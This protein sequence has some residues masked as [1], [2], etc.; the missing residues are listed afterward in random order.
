M[1]SKVGIFIYNGVEA[2][3]VVGPLEVF[4]VA[5]ELNGFTL[6]ET[7]VFAES[8]EDV[9]TVNGLRIL[10]EHTITTLPKLDVLII[11]GGEGIRAVIKDPALMNLISAVANDTQYMLTVCTGAFAA[12]QLG[13]LNGRPFCTHHSCYH[14]VLAIAPEALPRREERFVGDGRLF[15][16]AGVTAG[17]ELALHIVQLMHGEETSRKVVSYIEYPLS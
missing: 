17:I 6:F 15:S 16:S 4:S 12:A 8:S 1:R 13:W 7:F 3:D 11:P 2:L 10:P 14:E 9:K 5:D